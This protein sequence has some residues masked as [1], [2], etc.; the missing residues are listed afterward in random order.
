[1]FAL[2]AP[3]HYQESQGRSRKWESEGRKRKQKTTAECCSLTCSLWLAQLSFPYNSG[4]L[5]RGS[6]TYS[7]LGSHT[8]LTNEENSPQIFPQANL[9]WISFQLRFPGDSSLQLVNKNYPSH[10]VLHKCMMNK[11]GRIIKSMYGFDVYV[12]S[13]ALNGWVV[14]ETTLYFVQYCENKMLMDT[15]LIPNL[16][17]SHLGRGKT[18]ESMTKS[19]MRF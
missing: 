15:L 8:S 12:K 19:S 3:V 17:F 16:N 18:I 1:M 2:W 14:A 10:S 5:S 6:N 7:G 4:H 13:T 11:K 9:L